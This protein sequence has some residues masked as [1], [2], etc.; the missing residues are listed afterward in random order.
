MWN[1]NYKWH[2]DYARLAVDA[3]FVFDTVKQQNAMDK[4]KLSLADVEAIIR[5][6]DVATLECY[7]PMIT[8]FKLDEEH[9]QILDPSFLKLFRLSQLSLDYLVFCKAYL[10]NSVV[11]L[12]KEMTKTVQ[13]NKDLKS[14]I[15][16]LKIEVNE[17]R[18]DLNVASFKCEQCSKLFA[19]EEYLS[20]HIRRR[21]EV[22]ITPYQEETNKLQLEIKQLK[23]RLNSTEKIVHLDEKGS[24]DNLD[25]SK[26]SE[27]QHK[28]EIL[29]VHVENEL[30]LMQTQKN[31]QEKYERWFEDAFSKIHTMSSDSGGLKVQQ[32][33]LGCHRRDSMTQTDTLVK[34]VVTRDVGVSPCRFYEEN[35]AKDAVKGDIDVDKIKREITNETHEQIGK[36]EGV[37]EEMVSLCRSERIKVNASVDY[38]W[39][40][41]LFK[42]FFLY[43]GSKQLGKDGN[44]DANLVEPNT[45][46]TQSYQHTKH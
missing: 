5:E 36:V 17:L 7:I 41:V 2:F 22:Q 31:F 30:K 21:H 43:K 39:S 16:E 46:S 24:Q 38:R 45:P 37:L 42:S 3:G 35:V 19:T 4:G 15:N 6:K 44:T 12:K 14:Y 20:A 10:D 33:D 32:D 27:L 34:N 18:K 25:N 8:S 26:V 9:S 29:K 28:F 11:V 13:E 1:K 23:E 40:I